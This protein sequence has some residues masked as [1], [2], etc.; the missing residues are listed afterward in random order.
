MKAQMIDQLERLA[1][2]RRRG[3]TLVV[4]SKIYGGK[5]DRRDLYE[6]PFGV[7]MLA[8]DGVDYV[9]DLEKP[10]PSKVGRFD[11][12]DCCSVL[13]HV[14]RPWLMA[15]NITAVVNAGA[16]ILICV[17]FIWRLHDYPGDYWRISHEGLEVLFPEVR[18]KEKG[19]L[20]GG[21]LRKGIPKMKEEGWMAKAET[22]A[23]G[24]FHV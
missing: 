2:L 20:V 21:E 16:T 7:D 9:H 4:G 12:V 1:N 14:K 8:G 23:F 24:C 6:K 19:F 11:H 15:A 3:R 22:V 10:L 13:E 18:W 17:P 5:K